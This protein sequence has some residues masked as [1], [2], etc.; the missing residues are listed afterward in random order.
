MYVFK[1]LIHILYNKFSTGGCLAHKTAVGAGALVVYL[2]YLIKPGAFDMFNNMAFIKSKLNINEPLTD[3]EDIAYALAMGQP[4][5][6]LPREI[7]DKTALRKQDKSIVANRT[8]LKKDYSQPGA[9]NNNVLAAQLYGK[10]EKEEYYAN[11]KDREE[12][13]EEKDESPEYPRNKKVGR[14]SEMLQ[15][16]KGKDKN[17]NAD[18]DY[19]DDDYNVK[20]DDKEDNVKND[21][22]DYPYYDV[23][24]KKQR[25]EADRI[26][27]E[28]KDQ[29]VVKRDKEGQPLPAGGVT[30]KLAV[31]GRPEGPSLGTVLLGFTAVFCVLLF[32]VYRFIK[33]RRVHIHYSIR[34]LMRRM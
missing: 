18:D 5:Q 23:N 21:D 31:L 8:L 1:C 14:D 17:D 12:Y 32:F 4:L 11:Q 34:S 22:R 27:R 2:R 26:E 15:F 29:Y 24:Q 3:N 7:Q 19:K 13:Y 30:E 20:D 10:P 33:S 16:D 6:K 9:L 25:E 28:D